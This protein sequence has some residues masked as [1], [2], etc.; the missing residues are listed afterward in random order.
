M[1][2]LLIGLALFCGTPAAAQTTWIGSYQWTNDAPLFGGFSGIEVTEGGLSFIAVSDRGSFA[3]GTITRDSDTV[4]DVRLDAL[5]PIFG[6]EG[7]I[8]VSFDWNLGIRQFAAIDRPAGPLLT[9]PEFAK[10]QDNSL[11]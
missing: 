11:L 9:T 8:F 5:Q 6:P 3:R 2:R 4:T 7:T 1:L 10:M